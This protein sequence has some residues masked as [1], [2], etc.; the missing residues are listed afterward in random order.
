MTDVLGFLSRRSAVALLVALAPGR[1]PPPA[2]HA[3]AAPV[4]SPQQLGR[5]QSPDASSAAAA[6]RITVLFDNTTADPRLRAA[7]GFSA[8]IERA[9]HTLLLDAGGDPRILMGNLDSLGIGVRRIEAI[10]VSHAHG[11][12]V[13]GLPGL[14][15]RGVR[16]PLF[17]LPSFPPGF[18]ER[19]GRAFSLAETSR[20]QEMTAGVFTTGEMVD[21][22][23]RIPEQALV[24]P[25]DSGLVIV[26]GCAHQGVVAVVR[27]AV[28]MFHA[29]VYMVIGGFHLLDKSEPQVQEII[30]EFRRLGVRKV[31]ATHCT[32]ERAIAMFAA[33]YGA[34]FV[35]LG[36]GRV[37]VVGG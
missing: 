15:E 5:A 12:H 31:G 17:M 2:A 19:F 3:T 22:A 21:P 9:G 26:T 8:L 24:I 30:A 1:T 20:G 34:D 32:G 16:V 6:L 33:A 4:T 11:D 37:L 13:D 18:R 10:A 35:P 25:T 29:P 27:R 7:W 36:A 14:V 28:E 23:V